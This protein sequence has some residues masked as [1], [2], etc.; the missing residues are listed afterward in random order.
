MLIVYGKGNTVS[1][2]EYWDGGT[3][4]NALQKFIQGEYKSYEDLIDPIKNIISRE[5]SSF[6]FLERFS[7]VTLVKSGVFP[8]SLDNEFEL[9]ETDFVMLSFENE[10]RRYIRV[11]PGIVAS[12]GNI[13]IHKPAT[14]LASTQLE[15]ILG[16]KDK[17]KIEIK[18]S[19]KTDSFKCRMFKKNNDQSPITTYD[20]V[21]NGDWDNDDSIGY[22]TGIELI[23]A[24]YIDD[25]WQELMIQSLGDKLTKIQLEETIEITNDGNYNWCLD[26]SG[27]F[28]IKEVI[29]PSDM[30]I[31]SFIILGDSI[32]NIDN[33]H[34][35][36]TKEGQALLD[37]DGVVEYLSNNGV[38]IKDVSGSELFID[39]TGRITLSNGTSSISISGSDIS[40][41]GNLNVEGTETKLNT[42]TLEV[43]DNIIEINKGLTGIPPETL[44]SGIKILRGDSE[45]YLFLFNETTKEFKVGL[46]NDLRRI[47]NI[48]DVPIDNSIC[49]WNEGNNRIETSETIKYINNKIMT[50]ID[51][52][53]GLHADKTA[54]DNSDM[55]ATKKNIKTYVDNF[56]SL[57]RTDL[58]AHIEDVSNPHNVT[59]A[60]VGLSN[61]PNWNGSTNIILGNSDSTIS[62]QKAIKTYVDNNIKLHTDKIDNPH[63]VTQ[64]QV[65]LSDVPN[66]SA[67]SNNLGSSDNTFALEKAVSEALELKADNH[68]HPYYTETEVN[69][70]LSDKSDKTHIHNDIYYTETE[71]DTKLALKSDKTHIHDGRYF[72]ETEVNNKFSGFAKFG[73]NT[74]NASIGATIAHGLGSNPSSVQIT[75]NENP[76]GYL[77]E[78]WVTCDDTNINVYCSGSATTGFYWVVFK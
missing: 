12:N 78:I 51:T 61:A 30:K 62:S 32:S 20:Y 11:S 60:Q 39:K 74:F 35:L 52:I 45:A 42:Q 3:K 56:E 41:V 2:G 75:P 17:E 72:T 55:L 5:F 63:N 57:L 59:Q 33:S 4:S 38:R 40:I 27:D 65:G 19:Y 58:D 73:N 49:F 16:F 48:E 71:I 43:A 28:I 53:D 23:N 15:E 10:E 76:D 54:I 14:E 46:E 26:N 69:S 68:P 34:T 36:Y 9:K 24:I 6:D 44:T 77:G 67:G 70:L 47:A 31:A 21:A 37:Q 18:Y 13:Y 64:A 50:D 7:E 66:W 8:N 29:E 1:Q 22:K 25:K